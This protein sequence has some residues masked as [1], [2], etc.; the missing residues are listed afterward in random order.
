[1]ESWIFIGIIAVCLA[2]VI[3]IFIRLTR[4]LRNQFKIATVTIV[5]VACAGSPMTNTPSTVRIQSLGTQTFPN[6]AGHPINPNDYKMFIVRGSSML[7]CGIQDNDLLFTRKITQSD[8]VSFDKPHVFV[9]RRDQYALADAASKNDMAK[10]KVRRAWDVV[11][12]GTEDIEER[13]KQIMASDGFKELKRN[14]PDAFLSDV[15]MLEDFK[16]ERMKKYM[17]QYPDSKDETDSNHVAIISTTLRAS[18][19]DKVFFSIHPARIIVGEVIY[20]FHKQLEPV[21]C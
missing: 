20:S 18:K 8:D 1:M 16:T 9:L 6:E 5:D 21:V 2:F 19:N 11:H 17:E 13:V 14:H 4:I 10:Y 12:I 15:E 7:L 3:F